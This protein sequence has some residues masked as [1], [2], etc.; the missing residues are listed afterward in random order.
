MKWFYFLPVFGPL[1]CYVRFLFPD[2]QQIPKDILGEYHS[3]QVISHSSDSGVENSNLISFT[4]LPLPT[5]GT[6]QG[7]LIIL[8]SQSNLLPVLQLGAQRKIGWPAFGYFSSH[9]S[10][11]AEI[12]RKRQKN[13]CLLPDW[14][15]WNFLFVDSCCSPGYCSAGCLMGGMHE[16]IGASLLHYLLNPILAR[17]PAASCYLRPLSWPAVLQRGAGKVVPVQLSFKTPT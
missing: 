1:F 8:G 12:R 5:P 15:C 16:F 4:K 14:S 13:S 9:F 11:C 10:F 3:S 6:G 7:V 2:G 17:Y